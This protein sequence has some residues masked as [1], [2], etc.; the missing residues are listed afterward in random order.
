VTAWRRNL[1]LGLIVAVAI[2]V[3]ARATGFAAIPV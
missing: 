3:I 2:V 1:L